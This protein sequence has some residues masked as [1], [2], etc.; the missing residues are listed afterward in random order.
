MSLFNPC[1]SVWGAALQVMGD[2]IV[3]ITVTLSIFELATSAGSACD[4]DPALVTAFSNLKKD[5]SSPEEEYKVACLLLVFVAVSLPLLAIDPSSVYVS[6]ING[7]NNNIHC[8]AK[9]IIQVSAALFTIYNKNIESHLKEFLMLASVSL[10]QLGQD[11]DK[12]KAKNK[13]SISLLMN[14]LVEELSFLT[15]DMLETCFPYV[16]LRNAYREVSRA[17]VLSRLPAH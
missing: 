12:M 8:L 6:E 5:G 10:L 14:L 2:V 7:Y 11:V 15:T 1:W 9:A 13:E 4:I 3:A 17:S 16:L